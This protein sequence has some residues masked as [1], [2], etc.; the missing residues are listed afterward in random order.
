MALVRECLSNLHILAGRLPILP[1]SQACSDGGSA[2]LDFE[3]MSGDGFSGLAVPN[4]LAGMSLEGAEAPDAGTKPY[5]QHR[6]GLYSLVVICPGPPAV[7]G[8]LV[9]SAEIRPKHPAP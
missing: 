5:E 2:A 1:M 7:M 4:Q 8:V 6:E 9:V 3:N